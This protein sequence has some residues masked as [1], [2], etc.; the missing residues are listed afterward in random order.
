MQDTVLIYFHVGFCGTHQRARGGRQQLWHLQQRTLVG[1]NAGGQSRVLNSCCLPHFPHFFLLR[2]SFGLTVYCLNNNR[3]AEKALGIL[4]TPCIEMPS[5]VCFAFLRITLAYS[6]VSLRGGVYS[7]LC[8]SLCVKV[9]VSCSLFR[10]SACEF[11][12]T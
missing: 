1:K 6:H 3:R 8:C 7:V 11:M 4:L 12:K 2:F 10:S 9:T 5:V